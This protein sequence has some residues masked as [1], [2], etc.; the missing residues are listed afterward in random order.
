MY[1]SA[2]SASLGTTALSGQLYKDAYD[3]MLGNTTACAK[4]ITLVGQGLLLAVFVLGCVGAAQMLS[5]RILGWSLVGLGLG[6]ATIKLLAGELK[7]RRVDLISSAAIAS[8]L[9]VFGALGVSG[10][11]A[12]AHM[13]YAIIGTV[14][15]VAVSTSSMMIVAKRLQEKNQTRIRKK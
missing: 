11:M 2:T 4:V 12:S 13:G 5:P 6:Y 10:V 8:L 7:K 14:S 3:K 9:I 15:T 1:I